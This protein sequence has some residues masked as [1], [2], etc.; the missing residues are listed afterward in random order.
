MDKTGGYLDGLKPLAAKSEI[1]VTHNEFPLAS[2][3]P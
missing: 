1:C 3:G 2:L